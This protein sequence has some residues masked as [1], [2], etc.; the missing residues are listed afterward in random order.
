[1]KTTINISDSLLTHIKKIAKSKNT[2][3][4]E[5][6]ESALRLFLNTQKNELNSFKLRTHTFTGDGLQND[7]KEGDW[8]K[9]KS[10]IYEGRGA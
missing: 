5:I 6:I 4:K 7:I 3:I 9:I 2:S 1:M 8:N 10:N